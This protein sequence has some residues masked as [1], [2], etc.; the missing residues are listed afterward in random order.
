MPRR[1]PARDPSILPTGRHGHL[2]VTT[3]APPPTAAPSDPDPCIR[4]AIAHP[5]GTAVLADQVRPTDRVAVIVDDI[6][7]PTPVH[8]IL[9]RVLGS[10]ADIGVPRG[11]ITIVIALGSHRPMTPVEIRQ[12]LGTSAAKNYRV[13]ND[14]ADAMNQMVDLGRTDDGVPVW[15]H[16]A[17]AEADRRIGIGT[18]IPHLDAGF[19]GGAKIVLP[20][21]CGTPTVDAFH[22]RMARVTINPLGMVDATLRRDLERF[23]AD[24]VPLHFI[25]NVILSLDGELLATV[26]GDAVKAHRAGAHVARRVYGAPVD[27]RYPVVVAAARPHDSD[28]WQCTKALAAGE[29]LTE[30]GGW[31][32]L[33]ADCPDGVGPH[34][35]FADYMGMDADLLLRRIDAADVADP[36]AAAEAV[37]ICRMRRRLTIA[38]VSAGIDDESTRRMGVLRFDSIAEAIDAAVAKTHARDIGWLPDGG[39]TLPLLSTRRG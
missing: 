35:R 37:A 5:I 7:R 25:V 23:V 19:G 15:V 2:Q 21:V 12:K 34:P 9:P 33:A 36:C 4:K 27:R 1:P 16:Q 38:V 28:L 17:V 32:I 6:T 26:A 29:M 18:I 39:T 22:S 20:G 10:L 13:V 30:D 14:P 11:S 8:A 31:L 3:I 24:V